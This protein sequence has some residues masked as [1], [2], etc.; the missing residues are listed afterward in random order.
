M[1]SGTKITILSNKKNLMSRAAKEMDRLT[2]Q[3]L[4]YFDYA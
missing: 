4:A 3:I 1:I 2:Q